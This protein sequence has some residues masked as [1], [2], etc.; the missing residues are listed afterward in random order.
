M[1]ARTWDQDGEVAELTP[2]QAADSVHEGAAS[3]STTGLM[4]GSLSAAYSAQVSL[5]VLK[6]ILDVPVF[7]VVQPVSG[8][9][10]A[11][12]NLDPAAPVAKASHFVAAVWAGMVGWVLAVAKLPFDQFR[13]E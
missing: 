6:R 2:E 8:V 5:P 7:T 9:V 11:S 13:I 3:S 4:P 12:L 1:G 10:R